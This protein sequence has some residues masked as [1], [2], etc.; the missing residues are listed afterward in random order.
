MENSPKKVVPELTFRKGLMSALMGEN[1]NSSHHTTLA[2]PVQGPKNV[3][4]IGRK[5]L[6]SD[7]SSSVS[8]NSNLHKIKGQ[9][10]QTMPQVALEAMLG[11][12]IANV[13]ETE[14]QR[15]QRQHIRSI[16]VHDA[17]SVS[18][19]FVISSESIKIIQEIG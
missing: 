7:E 5:S 8:E 15:S 14:R 17:I 13:S 1:P 11:D 18:I 16:R 19:L 2:V 12:S 3:G 6:M 10:V 4:R 9:I